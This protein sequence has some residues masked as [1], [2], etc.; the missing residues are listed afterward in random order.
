MNRYLL[1]LVLLAGFFGGT[2]MAG[3]PVVDL[4][5][6][7]GE[8]CVDDPDYMR[9][10]HMDLLKHHRDEALREGV[11]TKQYSLQQCFECHM[12]DDVAKKPQQ[13]P[14]C[15]ACHSYIGASPDCIGCHNPRATSE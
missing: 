3:V 2:V 13:E 7:K 12:A 14:F 11:R 5:T 1:L 15:Q 4:P 8:H 6:P 9:R 10:H